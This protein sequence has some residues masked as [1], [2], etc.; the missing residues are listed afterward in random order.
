MR[1]HAEIID[2]AHAGEAGHLV[3]AFRW[4]KPRCRSVS[5]TSRSAEG[6]EMVNHRRKVL[7]FCFAGF[8]AAAISSVSSVLAQE[9]VPGRW[10]LIA[11]PPPN[12]AVTSEPVVAAAILLD[13]ATG[14]TW[15][16]VCVHLATGGCRTQWIRLDRPLP[17]QQQ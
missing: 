1:S 12:N 11:L 16:L 9:A 6:N 3:F 5:F 2:D 7:A 17:P 14:D 4:P 13:T 8:A 10:H 15:Q